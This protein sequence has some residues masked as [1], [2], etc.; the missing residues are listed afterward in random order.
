MIAAVV[1]NVAFHRAL[2]QPRLLDSD[3]QLAILLVD[4]LDL[5]LLLVFGLDHGGGC[6]LQAV[7]GFLLRGLGRVRIGRD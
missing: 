7:C 3:A 5:L 2:L 6:C 1:E 4:L